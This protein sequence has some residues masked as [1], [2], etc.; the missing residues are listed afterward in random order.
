VEEGCHCI[1]YTYRKNKWRRGK[2]GRREGN[3][4]IF[5]ISVEYF[6]ARLLVP[7]VF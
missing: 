7:I 3:Q 5:G 2:R 6:K 1:F 4:C